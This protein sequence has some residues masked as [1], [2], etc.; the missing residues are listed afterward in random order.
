LFT[1][2]DIIDVNVTDNGTSTPTDPL[3]DLEIAA[4]N[5]THHKSDSQ[6]QA[7]IKQ[8]HSTGHSKEYSYGH[9][10]EDSKGHSKRHSKKSPKG[11][12][13]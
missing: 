10:E 9:S 13:K 1:A 2:Y 4:L 8:K 6:V 3:L 11:H 5:Q 12:S 7:P